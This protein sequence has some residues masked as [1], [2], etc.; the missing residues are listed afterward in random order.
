MNPFY[1]A[2]SICVCLCVCMFGCY[3]KKEKKIEGRNLRM[4]EYIV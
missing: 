2:I 4:V 1:I 3:G